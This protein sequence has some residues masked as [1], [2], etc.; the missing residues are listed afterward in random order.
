MI[1]SV[2]SDLPTDELEGISEASEYKDDDED[3]RATI[4]ELMLIHVVV[5]VTENNIGP[6]KMDEDDELLLPRDRRGFTALTLHNERR[7]LGKRHGNENGTAKRETRALN[8]ES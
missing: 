8:H 7:E 3:M 2:L 4:S 5:D 1:A 6:G